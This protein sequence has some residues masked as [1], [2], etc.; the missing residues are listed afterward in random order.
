M[1]DPTQIQQDLRFVRDAVA[2]RSQ[3]RTPVA[4]FWIVAV[5][6]LI[7]YA[8]LDVAPQWA[9]WILGI[10]GVALW[11]VNSLVARHQMR[12]AGEY[13]RKASLRATLHWG[14]GIT[15]A[16]VGCVALAAVVPSLR[17][18]VFG[19]MVVI[20]IGLVYF[21]G[22]IHFD[23]QFLWLGPVLIAG[24]VCV[25]FVPHYGWTA[26]GVV[27]ALG[28]VVPTFFKRDDERNDGSG[29]GPAV[30]APV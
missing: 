16:I 23:R 2:R 10:G 28:L 27:I 11:G 4:I 5:Y 24:G 6:V 19:Q 14:G 12:T 20:M 3:R 29:V 21:L 25:K 9:G 1:T 15:L 26:L 30:A 18:P 8:M 13:D 7:G 22:G 17:G